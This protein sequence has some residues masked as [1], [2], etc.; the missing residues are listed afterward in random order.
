MKFILITRAEELLD[1]KS[2]THPLLW[3]TQSVSAREAAEGAKA[4]WEDTQFF[5]AIC[6]VTHA[7]TL[8]AW[9]FDFMIAAVLLALC[10]VISFTMAF[11]G[12]WKMISH[13]KEFQKQWHIAH[14]VYHAILRGEVP[15]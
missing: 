9:H 6:L 2:Y 1:D 4:H 14:E 12:A 10:S 5:G 15:S 8:V 13:L 7:M 11:M 3:R